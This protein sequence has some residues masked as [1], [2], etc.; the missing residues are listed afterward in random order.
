[1][2]EKFI[3]RE[4]R[5]F[6]V[7]QEFRGYGLNFVLVG[8]YAI[9]AFHHRFSV[10]ADVVVKGEELQGFVEALEARGF[11]EVE[12]KKL[13]TPYGGR[14]LSYMRKGELPVSI[15][16][17]VNSLE[18]RQTGG[19]WSY[20]YLEEHSRERRVEGSEKSV[21]ARIPGKELL[22][23]IKLHS[24]RMTDVRDAVA[25]AP[26]ADFSRVRK[27]LERGDRQRLK[28]GLERVLRIIDSEGFEDS[29]KGVFST[30]QAPEES[31]HLLRSFIQE[32]TG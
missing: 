30:K 28:E 26:G 12:E 29:F 1:V 27:H 20:E 25:M 21:V 32:M 15:D 5:I 2:I 13:D 22:M 6:E 3:R 14:F 11:E 7:L 24:G 23:A 19:S 16:L 17:L 10:D 31:V 8:G 9:S 18:C 4:N